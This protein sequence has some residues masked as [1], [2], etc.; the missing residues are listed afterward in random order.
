MGAKNFP[1]RPSMSYSLAFTVL[2]HHVF[3]LGGKIPFW[4][5]LSMFG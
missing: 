4:F 2:L 5:L 1:K 3:P